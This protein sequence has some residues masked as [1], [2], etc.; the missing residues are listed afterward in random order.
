MCSKSIPTNR[1]RTIADAA[2][3]SRV[4]LDFDGTKTTSIGLAFN[5]YRATAT[6]GGPRLLTATPS[7]V[8][9]ETDGVTRATTYWDEPVRLTDDD[10]TIFDASGDPVEFAISNNETNAVTI[11][12]RSEPAGPRRSNA[13]PLVG[14]QYTI[15]T[16]DTAF[17]VDNNAPIDGDGDGIS[18]GN[19]TFTVAH[20]CPADQNQDGMVNGLDFGA[21]LSNFNAGCP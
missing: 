18:G 2:G 19:V 9:T 21:W 12:F 11:T 15:T 6:L 3:I 1:P 7:I 8:S 5:N 17:A 13:I 4:E 16:A 14:G 20:S 10:V